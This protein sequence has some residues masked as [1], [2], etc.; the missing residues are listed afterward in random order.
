M[1]VVTNVPL[2]TGTMVMQKAVSPVTVTSK[3]LWE[4]TAT[5]SQGSVTV[6]PDLEG[7]TAPSAKSTT[8]GTHRLSVKSAAVTQWAHRQP[9][10]TEKQG[11]ANA[12]RGWQEPDVMSVHAASRASSPTVSDVTSA[13]SCGMT[14]CARLEET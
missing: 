14:T 13:S 2:T 8:G 11:S 7:N 3:M 6:V 1:T 12:R 4:I 5:C 9:S 10:V